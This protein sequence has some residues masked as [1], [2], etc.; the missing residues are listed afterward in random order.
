[1]LL[2]INPDGGIIVSVDMSSVLPQRILRAAVLDLKGNALYEVR[3]KRDLR[4]NEALLTALRE[5]ITEL[6]ARSG[7]DL[8]RVLTIGISVPGLVDSQSGVLVSANIGVRQL[9]LSEALESAFGVPILVHNSEDVAALGEYFFGAGREAASLMYLTVGYGVG[10]GLVVDGHIFPNG[11]ISAGE[12]GHTTVQPDG[13]LCH[14]GNRGCLSAVVNSE[15]M[16]GQV[17]SAVRDG[18]IST[19]EALRILPEDE[20]NLTDI[21]AAAESGDDLCHE[22]VLQAAEWLGIAVANLINLLNLEMI[23]FD[24]ELFDE[25]GFFLSLVTGATRE[26][27]FGDYLNTVKL[28]RSTLGRSASLKGVGVLAIDDIFH[29]TVKT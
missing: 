7:V 29:A 15:I 3:H 22:I 12:I 26:R 18:Y 19:V 5:I 20:I 21:L 14:C 16:V 11:R 23:V 9:H 4:G 6:F 1:V 8:Q 10:A 28:M 13:P 17:R 24:G 2:G 25:S 27:A